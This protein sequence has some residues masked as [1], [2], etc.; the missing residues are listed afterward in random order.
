MLSGGGP[1]WPTPAS[2][3]CSARTDSRSGTSV[4]SSTTSTVRGR[5]PFRAS[6]RSSNRQP[7]LDAEKRY[8]HADKL[9]A[10][11]HEGGQQT[12]R[13]GRVTLDLTAPIV[14]DETAAREH[15]EAE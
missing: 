6:W 9:Q 4:V 5:R 14:T 13:V 11:L 1:A 10:A 7:L 15:L 3:A 12:C 8:Y 2:R